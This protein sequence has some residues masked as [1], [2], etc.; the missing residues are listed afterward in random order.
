MIEIG[1]QVRLTREFKLSYGPDKPEEVLPAGSL[2]IV[3]YRPKDEDPSASFDIGV[4]WLTTDLR[5]TGIEVAESDVEVLPPV[6]SV[7]VLTGLLRYSWNDIGYKHSGLTD[8][9]K[10]IVSPEQ[11]VTLVNWVVASVVDDIEL[12]GDRQDAI[13][14]L[15]FVMS[16]FISPLHAK[17]DRPGSVDE[18]LFE[19]LVQRAVRL[20]KLA[21]MQARE[22]RRLA[23][24]ADQNFR[25]SRLTDEEPPA[26]KLKN[27]EEVRFKIGQVVYARGTIVEQGKK[28]AL[29][30]PTAKR[31]Q[32]GWVYAT[33]GDRGHVQSVNGDGYPTV[34]FERTDS[35]TILDPE[36]IT[37]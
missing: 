13:D 33:A 23:G 12:D 31:L 28:D 15:D 9:E 36:E 35:A 1:T 29:P 17:V 32:P 27:G 5:T 16:G 22:I 24:L 25:I 8:S 11:F 19:M 18:K 6:S 21:D 10:A 30:D 34:R 7:A 2:G 26:I 14:L 4:T 37:W 20:K 3:Q